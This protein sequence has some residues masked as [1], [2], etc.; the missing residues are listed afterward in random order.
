MRAGQQQSA[1]GQDDGY[2]TYGTI[3]DQ[4]GT[5]SD[6]GDESGLAYTGVC[7]AVAK[8]IDQK[9]TVC[10]KSLGNGQKPYGLG[11]VEDGDMRT[12][13]EKGIRNGDEPEEEKDEDVSHGNAREQS[14][15][16]KAEYHTGN[17]HQ[18]TLHSSPCYKGKARKACK[19]GDNADAFAHGREGNPS[20]RAG[21]FRAKAFFCIHSADAVEIVVHKI[22][23][24]LHEQ[25]KDHAQEGWYPLNLSM[26]SISGRYAQND[27]CCCAGK[28]LRSGSKPPGVERICLYHEGKVTPFFEYI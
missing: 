25:C 20:L 6:N 17:T 18:Y 15:I 10:Y 23:I 7:V 24:C 4:R 1:E 8:V 16:E 12:L 11:D 14:G 3:N 9:Q 13:E 2:D 19:Q 5:F 22:G 26:D 21:A 27:R 28:G